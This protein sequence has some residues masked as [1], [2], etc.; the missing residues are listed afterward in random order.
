MGT[1]QRIEKAPGMHQ[2]APGLKTP[3]AAAIAGILFSLLLLTSLALLLQSVQVRS[4]DP[5]EWLGPESWK[6]ALALNLIPFAGIAFLWFMGVL[7][8][9][10]GRAEDRLFATVFLGS[11][12]LFVGLLFVSASAIGAILIADAAAPN[13]LRGSVAFTLARS[14]AYHLATIYA[15][16]MAGVFLMT[17]STIVLRTAITARWTALLGY[18]AAALILL[19]S[20]LLDWTFFVFPAWVLIVSIAILVEEFRPPSAARTSSKAVKG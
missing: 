2:T 8:D 19:G 17:A 7:R 1:V 12:L 14:L 20:Q 13:E 4:T 18:A 6:V 10:L 3:R 9:R 16:K 11:G 5:G 15:L